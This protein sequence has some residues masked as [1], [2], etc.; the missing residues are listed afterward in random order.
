[1][2]YEYTIAGKKVIFKRKIT[3][4]EAPEFFSLCA[5]ADSSDPAKMVPVL[6]FL[7]ES[8]EFE[9][10]PK[11][12]E[13]YDDMD[14]IEEFSPLTGAANRFITERVRQAAAKNS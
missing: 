5:A 3:V 11:A 4:R 9:G 1:M 7:I 10:D 14:V 13:S 2:Q 12:A 8:W 6:R